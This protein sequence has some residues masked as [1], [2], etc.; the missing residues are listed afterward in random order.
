MCCYFCGEIT[1]PRQHIIHT[2]VTHSFAEAPLCGLADGVKRYDC[3]NILTVKSAKLRIFADPKN[4]KPKLGTCVSCLG[5]GSGLSFG[6]E[7]AA[8]A[9]LG[10]VELDVAINNKDIALDLL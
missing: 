2:F 5:I 1:C 4:D 7:A 8:S 10:S 6:L 9:L 3:V